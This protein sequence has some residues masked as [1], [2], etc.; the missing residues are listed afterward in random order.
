M[1]HVR[2]RHSS[3]QPAFAA[4]MNGEETDPFTP[5]AGLS[6]KAMIDSNPQHHGTVQKLHIPVLYSLLPSFVQRLILSWSC[7]KSFAPSWKERHLILCGSYLYKFKDAFSSTPKGS[8]FDIEKINTDVVRTTELSEINLPVG[9]T[10]IFT[11]STLRRRHYYAV[12]D[13]EEAL[14]WVRSL[15]ESRHEAITRNMG[16]ASNVPYPPKWKHFD[17]LGSGLV[18]SKDR[19]KEK[20]EMTSLT[21]E[22]MPRGYYG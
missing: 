14:L 18:K 11:V 6:A 22:Q 20:L 5:G 8:P 2:Q 12:S 13:N 1:S 19:I 15:H 9:Y 7:F 10:S 3:R 17:S 16:H 21:D 4:P